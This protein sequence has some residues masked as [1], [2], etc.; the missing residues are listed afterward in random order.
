MLNKY[1]CTLFLNLQKVRSILSKFL[2]FSILF[3]E[4]SCSTELDVNAPYRETKVAYCI[5][6]PSEPFQTARISKGF[7]SDGRPASEIA[8]NSPDS[9][10][11][12]P[13]VLEVQLQE[14]NANSRQVIRRWTMNDTLFTSKEEGTF[15]APDQI[16]YKTPNIRLDSSRLYRLSIFNKR[17]GNRS[18]ATTNLIGRNLRITSPIADNPTLPVSIPFRSKAPTTIRT[19]K[20]NNAA[21]M[22]GIT[23]FRIQVKKTSRPDT[24]E[25]TWLWRSP[26]LF[27]I[28]SEAA[29]ATYAGNGFFSFIKTEVTTRGNQDVEWRRFKSTNLEITTANNE[30]EN[31]SLVNGNYN[32]I[33][34][35]VPTYTNF[36]QGLGVLCSRNRQ[37]FRVAPNNLSLDSLN[38]LVP[39][40]KLKK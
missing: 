29:N 32:A 38:I 12:D 19:S 3:L 33:T 23:I 15:Y 22:E 1:F 13:A 14:I 18:E 26:G 2:V 35:S 5:L 7:L 20:S 39:E 36:N 24:T 9:S 8:K 28:G 34:Q 11:Y 10:L 27:S 21:I 40:F 30:F 37:N 31:Y 17:T 16:V 25:E 4:F 6:D